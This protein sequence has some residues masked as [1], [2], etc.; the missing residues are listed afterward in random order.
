MINIYSRMS[1]NI[2][3]LLISIII[4]Y[5]FN[6]LDFNFNKMKFQVSFDSTQIIQE[7]SESSENLEYSNTIVE[8][9]NEE[10]EVEEIEET[11]ETKIDWRIEIPDIA[12]SAEIAEGTTK[13]VMD[14]YV[15]HFENTKTQNGNIG[16]AA[17]NRGYEVNYFENL[18]NLEYGAE[19][20]YKYG[21]FEKTYVVETIEIIKNTDW[22]YLEE[23]EDNRITLITCVEN[24]PE[25]RR[26]IQG[27]EKESEEF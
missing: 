6:N 26:C 14:K 4:F 8:Q 2:I 27:I 16:L 10:A 9:G 21:N 5:L 25:Y 15:G 1:V 11:K 12:L 18:K 7:S 23:T 13:E 17:H 22:S 3:A 20:I 24:Q 19:I